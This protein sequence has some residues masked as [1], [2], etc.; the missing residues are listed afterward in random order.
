MDRCMQDPDYLIDLTYVRERGV[1]P[2]PRN[3]MKF[4]ERMQQEVD[5]VRKELGPNAAAKEQEKEQEKPEMEQEG[6]VVL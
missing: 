5:A 4:A 1:R 3:A 2:T 6:A